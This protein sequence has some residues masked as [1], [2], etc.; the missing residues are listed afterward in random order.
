MTP[1]DLQPAFVGIL[2]LVLAGLHAAGSVAVLRILSV[3]GHHL[4]RLAE[5]EAIEHRLKTAEAKLESRK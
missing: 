5:L 3:C 4:D 1:F 2:C